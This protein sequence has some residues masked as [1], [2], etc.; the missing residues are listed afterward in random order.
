[1]PIFEEALAAEIGRRYG[2]RV[3]MMKLKHGMFDDACNFMITSE[4]G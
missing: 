1:M 2:H 3:E 4:M